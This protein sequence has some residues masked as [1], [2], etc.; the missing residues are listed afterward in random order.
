MIPNQGLAPAVLPTV[1]VKEYK[2][3]HAPQK[4][5]MASTLL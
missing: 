5:K 4:R 3:K 1:M 2:K